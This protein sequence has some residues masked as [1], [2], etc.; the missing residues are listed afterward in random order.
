MLLIQPPQK[1][2]NQNIDHFHK[3]N[4][5]MIP[6]NEFRMKEATKIMYPYL[7]PVIPV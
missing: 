1:K 7:K 6:N 4:Q 5:I 2:K 3:R